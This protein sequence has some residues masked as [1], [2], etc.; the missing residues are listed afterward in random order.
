L[1]IS[2]ISGA[3]HNGSARS[4]LEGEEV[5]EAYVLLEALSRPPEQAER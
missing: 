5:G 1:A 2:A 3:T 4:K